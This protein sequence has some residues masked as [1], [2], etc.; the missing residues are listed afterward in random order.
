MERRTA[1]SRVESAPPPSDM[2]ATAGLTAFAVTQSMPPTTPAV[3]PEPRQFSTLTATTLAPFASP[4]R[5]PAM[6]AA[7]CVPWPL[8]SVL[9]PSPEV[10]VPH[11]ARPPNV[12]CV[13]RTPVSMMYAVTLDAV[14]SY[15]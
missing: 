1:A 5:E 7:T 14:V 10:L 4:Y 3:G 9:L 15:W 8:Q 11:D 6:V 12:V 2:L 13:V